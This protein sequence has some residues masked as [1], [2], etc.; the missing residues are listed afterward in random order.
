MV[1]PTILTTSKLIEQAII[2]DG[3]LKP[4]DFIFMVDRSEIMYSNGDQSYIRK[5]KEALKV[6]IQ[7]LPYGSKFNIIG[8]GAT[9]E[10]FSEQQSLCL[11]EENIESAMA[12]IETYDNFE[13]CLGGYVNTDIY[14]N[15]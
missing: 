10:Q 8:Y 2:P 14:S 15:E 6:I 4:Q 12:D 3:T 13:R 9:V 1:K 7:S 5:V 11:N